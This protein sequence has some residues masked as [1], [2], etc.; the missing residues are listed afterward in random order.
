MEVSGQP[1][2]PAALPLGKILPPATVQGA[3]W[4]P[5]LV[6][7]F[8]RGEKYLTIPECEPQIIHTVGYSLDCAILAPQNGICEKLT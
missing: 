1:H 6:W 2:A 8:G 7:T 5:E 4:A 3:G